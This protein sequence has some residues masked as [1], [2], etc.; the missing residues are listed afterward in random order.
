L[1]PVEDCDPCAATNA[2]GI[3]IVARDA[4]EE[5]GLVASLSLE[6]EA[7]WEPV[8]R[9]EFTDSQKKTMQELEDQLSAPDSSEEGQKRIKSLLPKLNE[10]TTE[11]M[12]A[13]EK[14]QADLL[15]AA[16]RLAYL[17]G[18]EAV[19]A[20][21]HFIAAATESDEENR[22]AL[23]L[24]NGLSNSR[25]KQLQFN[26]LE[27]AWRDPNNLPGFE[28][29]EALRDARDLARDGMVKTDEFGGTE[30][31]RKI[32]V[33]HYQADLD[34]IIGTL[35]QRSESNRAQTIQ[36]LKKIAIPNPFN[37]GSDHP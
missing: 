14:R 2:V 19:R 9:P 18:D 35:P 23:I 6:L 31:E 28:L 12:A 30:E 13:I 26:L 33:K 1:S 17:E 3:E 29:H 22:I 16:R 37:Q 5:T 4:A 34:V 36:I 21:V 20:K 25:N 32:A 15:L 8:P 24:V 7:A 11:R 10:M 27:A